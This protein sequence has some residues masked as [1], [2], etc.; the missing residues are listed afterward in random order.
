MAKTRPA[1]Q[2]LTKVNVERMLKKDLD[3][4][5]AKREARK[6]EREAARA[7]AAAAKQAEDAAAAERAAQRKIEDAKNALQALWVDFCVTREIDPN[8]G[9]PVR[10][11][12]GE[13][14]T[15]FLA[16][17]GLN[18][19]GTPLAPVDKSKTP[20]DGP[21]I[22]LKT[23]RKHYV[24]AANGIECNGDPLALVCGQFSREIVV[25]GLIA[26][27]KLPNNPYSHLNPGQQSM[28]LRNKARAQIKAGM[29]QMSE[30]EAELKAEAAI[31]NVK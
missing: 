24:K 4:A 9:D 1:P 26:A 22:T 30:V 20:Y 28:N 7:A 19:D 14:F 8:G 16:E 18:A 17:Q 10:S 31:T 21:M 13:D 27:M 2:P 5:K 15:A 23:A 29:L 12:H 11:V 6:A 25:K 3:A